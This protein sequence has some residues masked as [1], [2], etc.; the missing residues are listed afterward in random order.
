[1]KRWTAVLLLL[2]MLLPL[3][4][5]AA[6]APEKSAVPAPEPS[7]PTEPEA[8]EEPPILSFVQ[9]DHF[10]E[11]K[12][13]VELS[14]QEGW[15]VFYTMNGDDPVK[16]GTPYT[17]AILLR[18]NPAVSVTAYNIRAA[19]KNE[20]GEWCPE[21]VHT[22]FIGEDI[23]ERF[24]A[25]VVSLSVAQED[26]YGE[27]GIY[28]NYN[29]RGDEWE[30]FAY[31][32]MFEPDGKRVI[33]QGAGVRVH[34]VG[35][36]NKP[37]KSVRIYARSEYDE[38]NNW[39][40][41]PFFDDYYAADGSP[42]IRS[43]RLVLRCCG[44]DLNSSFMR[45]TVAQ[46]LAADAGYEFT[47][48]YRPCIVFLNGAYQSVAWIQ[49][50]YN[51]YL[52]RERYGAFDGTFE[53]VDS[54]TGRTDFSIEKNR[55]F[56]ELAALDLT[57]DANYAKVCEQID[58]E[59]YLFYYA[60]NILLNNEDWPE[61]NVVRFR[62]LPAEGESFREAP[63]DG[64]WRFIIHDVDFILG[65]SNV[66]RSRD[67][68]LEVLD[69]DS[70]NHFSSTLDILP[71]SPLFAALM[72][73]EDC[74]LLFTRR[75]QML[76]NGPISSQSI[77]KAIN[78]KDAILRP[79][80]EY[81]FGGDAPYTRNRDFSYYEGQLT[82]MRTL[83]S[84]LEKTV[85]HRIAML[86]GYSGTYIMKYSANGSSGISID[87]LPVYGSGSV[88]NYGE[89]S[90]PLSPLLAPD[91]R[92]V[93]WMVDGQR[94]TEE[95]V[96]T[97]IKEIGQKLNVEMVT[98]KTEPEKR[99]AIFAVSA[100]GDKDYVILYNPTADAISTEGCF[101]S[102]GGNTSALR[103][104]TLAPGEKL[105]VYCRNASGADVPDEALRVDFS[106][107][108]GEKVVLT[109]GTELVEAVAVPELHPDGIL[110]KD[111]E[112]GKFREILY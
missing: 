57:D 4:S 48:R 31:V 54:D 12:L 89:I 87:G 5:C 46:Q 42:I 64:K 24:G 26:L 25:M 33:S 2:S 68:L 105:T 36:A 94:I 85:K 22:Y 110:E 50:K 80:L 75:I 13:S 69:P 43:K 66:H 28:D 106:L 96:W 71:Y 40:V 37:V 23:A 51:D 111:P 6:A 60:I 58:V 11:T 47:E 19:A 98:E 88:K 99:L 8:P 29:E 100:A 107:K 17:G 103:N 45:D 90:I 44:S 20:S 53:F 67:C 41:Y 93:C 10:Y 79:E 49:E 108:T 15:D 74:R 7:A 27:T 92:F 61:N 52:L 32:E 104:V 30:R 109:Y 86:W 55:E 95:T 59:N 38:E 91:E 102:D 83:I 1:M 78:E 65:Y 14:A 97:P 76:A 21:I 62:Y 72:E 9:Q 84:T 101:L 35:S 3:L 34:G 18:R 112:T 16:N 39:F 56:P 63:F 81:Y 77:T 70:L 73:R 82:K